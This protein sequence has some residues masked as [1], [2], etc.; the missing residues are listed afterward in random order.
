[1]ANTLRKSEITAG[2]FVVLGLAVLSVLIFKMGNFSP[3]RSDSY[4]ITAIFDDA[5]G[6][7]K[8][9][10]VQM[11]GTEIGR[12][13][14]GPTL[15]D[16]LRASVP[17]EIYA[18][19]RVPVGSTYRITSSG[20]LGDKLVQIVRPKGELTSFVGAGSI[21][22]GQS[23]ASLDQ[24][25]SDI[26]TLTKEAVA[27]TQM[28]QTTIGKA[29][30]ALDRISSLAENVDTMLLGA[31]N[32]QTIARILTNTDSL[33]RELAQVSSDL[34][35]TLDAVSRTLISI[36]DAAARAEQTFDSADSQIAK[37]EPALE[38]V[39]EAVRAITSAS[40]EA[41]QTVRDLRSGNGLLATLTKDEAVAADTRDFIRNLKRDGILRYQS[42]DE[43]TDP[44]ERYRGKRR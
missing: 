21:V 5:S 1:M 44:R 39:P 40:R 28:L 14:A 16:D 26:P 27:L 42:D 43:P 41:E 12:I 11:G 18:G 30:L 3:A 8:G 19:Q 2:L 6:L 31:Q 13:A 25:A 23:S 7:V 10:L 38:D 34:P 29:D 33:T 22:G 32:Q 15:T 37:L 35:S 20:L 4:Q 36:Q 24:L 17:L 9:G